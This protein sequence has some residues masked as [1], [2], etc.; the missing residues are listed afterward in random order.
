MIRR[1]P[2]RDYCRNPAP[3]RVFLW[4]G[5]HGSISAA[6]DGMSIK[7]TPSQDKI[8]SV[9]SCRCGFTSSWTALP[10][11]CLCYRESPGRDSRISLLPCAGEGSGMGETVM[12][13][14]IRSVSTVMTVWLAVV[15]P[16]AVDLASAEG[17]T[18]VELS[19]TGVSPRSGNFIHDLRQRHRARCDTPP[20]AFAAPE[21]GT[22]ARSDRRRSARS[23]RP[24]ARP[25]WHS[26]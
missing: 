13:F 5:K 6:D 17:E 12:I 1:I 22:D 7:R 4:C 18:S 25:S 23:G 3:S 2:G 9:S 14:L 24:S 11:F 10:R 26:P 19:G 15:L 20:R 16:C 8:A 21:A